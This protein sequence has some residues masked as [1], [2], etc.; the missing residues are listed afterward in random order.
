MLACFG[1]FDA[2]TDDLKLSAVAFNGFEMTKE[3]GLGGFEPEPPFF[4]KAKLEELVR[5]HA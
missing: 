2:T 1:I 3:Y 4:T 5:R